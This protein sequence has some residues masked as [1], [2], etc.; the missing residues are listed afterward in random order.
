MR[1]NT[2]AA[3]LTQAQLSGGLAAF[4]TAAR[5]GEFI[6]MPAEAN[7][8]PSPV[9]LRRNLAQKGVKNFT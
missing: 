5:V 9:F 7:Y 2:M 6:H 4:F 1:N 8:A 3:A